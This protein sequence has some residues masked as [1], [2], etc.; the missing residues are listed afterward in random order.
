MPPGSHLVIGD[1]G[2]EMWSVPPA[3]SSVVSFLQPQLPIAGELNA[4]PW[5]KTLT[6]PDQTKWIWGTPAGGL[7]VGVMDDHMD[8]GGTRV[9]IMTGMD[10]GAFATGCAG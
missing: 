8:A 2:Y 9:G 10:G 6:E 7:S 5:C 1:T 4:L 3:R